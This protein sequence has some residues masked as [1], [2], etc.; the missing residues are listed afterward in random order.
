MPAFPTSHAPL[1]HA[2]RPGAAGGA[3]GACGGLA[4]RDG[5]AEAQ[6]V[7][8]ARPVGVPAHDLGVDLDERIDVGKGVPELV[9]QL[10][11]V[12]ARLTL[13]GLGPELERDAR[14]VLQVL[15]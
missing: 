1:Q 13:V 10:S 4:D 14:A 6:Y 11:E 15:S 12:G 5:L 7:D 9:E 3:G 2:Q 8:F